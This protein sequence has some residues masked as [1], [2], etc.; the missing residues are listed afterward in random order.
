MWRLLLLAGFCATLSA[1]VRADAAGAPRELHGMA[2]V[3]EQ[4]DIGA[5]QRSLGLLA[6]AFAESIRRGFVQTRRV[7]HLEF[8]VAKEGLAL[9]PVAGDAWSVI[10]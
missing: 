5:D 2:A 6:H 9:A 8:E 4:R 3:I 10:D 1:A 7:E